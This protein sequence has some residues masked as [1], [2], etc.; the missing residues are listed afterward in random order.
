VLPVEFSSAR[1]ERAG[2][3]YRQQC[4]K[5]RHT[6]ASRSINL[7]SRRRQCD[8]GGTFGC[9]PGQHLNKRTMASSA[10]R[11]S[12]RS[13]Q[14]TRRMTGR[15]F[16]G[17]VSCDLTSCEVAC[18]AARKDTSY[19]REMC[20]RRKAGFQRGYS[21]WRVAWHCSPHR[22]DGQKCNVPMEEFLKDRLR[23]SRI[24]Q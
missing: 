20:H 4:W 14:P 8:S 5:R 7:M 19:K 24:H 17:G 22:S 18:R 1:L 13:C 16:W 9:A 15:I 21:Q 6:T 12:E 2:G 23:S 11:Y 3:T 10:A